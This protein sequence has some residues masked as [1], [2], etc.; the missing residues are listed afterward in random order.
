M[1]NP[2]D[3]E[4]PLE[5]LPAQ[6]RASAVVVQTVPLERS[7]EFLEWQQ[8]ITRYATHFPGYKYTEI[9]Q[10]ALGGKDAP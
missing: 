7:D 6:S 1:N 5:M 8:G 2:T 9:Y 4:I 10:P 3:R